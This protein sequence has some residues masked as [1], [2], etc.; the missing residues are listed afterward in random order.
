MASDIHDNPGAALTIRSTSARIAHN[1]FVRNG[2]SEP[3][4]RPFIIDEGANPL[5]TGN[6]FQDV[7]RDAFGDLSDGER[8]VMGLDN[9]FAEVQDGRAAWSATPRVRRG[10]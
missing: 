3:V 7:S 5:F 6:M 9:W 1:M 8:V 10:R 2:T 4:R